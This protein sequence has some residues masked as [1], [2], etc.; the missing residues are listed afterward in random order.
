MICTF[1]SIRAFF[2]INHQ[3]IKLFIYILI[4]RLMYISLNILS[5]C[6]IMYGH[7]FLYR[8]VTGLDLHC[9]DEVIDKELNKQLI[10][11][12]LFRLTGTCLL[13]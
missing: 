1:K 7:L 12:Y 5:S 3:E 13:F 2:N 9:F 4:I 11:D 6:E 8:T 10:S